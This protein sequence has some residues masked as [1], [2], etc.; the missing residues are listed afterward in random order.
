MNLSR[1]KDGRRL[2]RHSKWDYIAEVTGDNSFEAAAMREYFMKAEKC[3][4]LPQGTPG[5]GFDG[6]ITVCLSPACLD[7]SV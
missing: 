6:F 2:T 4:Y 1:T 5:H 7:A 3:N